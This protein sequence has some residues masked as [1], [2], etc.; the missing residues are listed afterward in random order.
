MYSNSRE[1]GIGLKKKSNEIEENITR[2]FL[3]KF[4][5]TKNTHTL[6]E[7]SESSSRHGGVVSPVDLSNV[8]ALDVGHLVHGKIASEWNL[9]Q[10]QGS[11]LFPSKRTASMF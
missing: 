7:L 9:T 11:I 3:L 1:P 4:I 8:V 2:L 10:G 6:I 5:F